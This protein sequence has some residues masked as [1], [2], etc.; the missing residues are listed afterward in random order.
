MLLVD[1]LVVLIAVGA[2]VT[3]VGIVSHVRSRTARGQLAAA[4]EKGEENA[5]K[6]FAKAELVCTHCDKPVDPE[7]DLFFK[8]SWFHQKCYNELL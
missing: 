8:K 5:E 6:F 4:R 7:V 2:T 1:L 3:G